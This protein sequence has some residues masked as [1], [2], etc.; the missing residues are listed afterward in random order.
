MYLPVKQ[1][2]FDDITA[3]IPNNPEYLLEYDYGDW[4]YIPKPEE[5]WAHFLVSIKFTK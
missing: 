2:A 3:Y 5:R 4:H 1:I